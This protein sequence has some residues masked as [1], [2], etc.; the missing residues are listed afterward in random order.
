METTDKILEAIEKS[1]SVVVKKPVK[2]TTKKP[3]KKV[4]KK[5]QIKQAGGRMSR[6]VMPRGYGLG[7]DLMDV[8]KKH[9][10]EG[11]EAL[12]KKA[13]EK[14][15]KGDIPTSKK[16]L[17]ADA[18]DLAKVLIPHAGKAGL[19]V[20]RLVAPAFISWFRKK[21]G[22]GQAQISDK[23]LEKYITYRLQHGKGRQQGGYIPSPLLIPIATTLAGAV[24]PEI[25]SFVSRKMQGKGQYGGGAGGIAGDWDTGLGQAGKIQ[26]VS[27][28]EG[29]TSNEQYQDWEN[30][31]ALNEYIEE[32]L[33]FE[34]TV[35]A[36]V[37]YMTLDAGQIPGGENYYNAVR[38]GKKYM[39]K[40]AGMMKSKNDGRG[41]WAPGAMR[42]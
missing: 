22:L 24:L 39:D 17:M 37:D 19:D 35:E 25:V 11:A 3:T 5:A 12:G 33:P 29:I 32:P 13:A 6:A 36:D 20:A 38:R 16:K 9:L 14:A 8:A 7:E 42:K 15:M 31:N 18:M 10:T 30:L 41:L 2:K 34:K 4:A 21:T 28:P 1:E 23:A 27:I 26:S 40:G